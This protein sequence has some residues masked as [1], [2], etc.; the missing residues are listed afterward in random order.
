MGRFT[1]RAA[2]NLMAAI[3]KNPR[4]S[5]EGKRSALKKLAKRCQEE[6]LLSM[7]RRERGR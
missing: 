3:V 5:E 2:C 7:I 1:A 4:M 6:K